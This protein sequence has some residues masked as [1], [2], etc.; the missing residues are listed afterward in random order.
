MYTAAVMLYSGTPPRLPLRSPGCRM[1][2][3]VLMKN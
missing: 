1:P 2:L 3:S